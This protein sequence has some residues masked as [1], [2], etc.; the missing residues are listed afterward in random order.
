M[1]EPIPDSVRAWTKAKSVEAIAGCADHGNPWP[2]KYRPQDDELAWFYHDERGI[3]KEV[4][5]ADSDAWLAGCLTALVV[6][7]KRIVHLWD[8]GG[9][10][11]DKYGCFLTDDLGAT[12]RRASGIA[13]TLRAAIIR[14]VL[15]DDDA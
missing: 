1:S 14:A 11:Y 3:S 5:D 9:L 6:N 7:K 12:D 10:E 4:P 2:C 15:G 8:T 13:P